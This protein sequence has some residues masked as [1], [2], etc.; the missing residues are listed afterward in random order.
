MNITEYKVCV[1]V[2]NQTACVAEHVHVYSCMIFVYVTYV[3]VS[4]MFSI[5]LVTGL[6]RMYVCMYGMYVVV[7]YLVTNSYT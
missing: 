2:L 4:H 7:V 5:E 6:Y 3:C 1:R